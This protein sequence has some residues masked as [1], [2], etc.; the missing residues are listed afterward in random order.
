MKPLIEIRGL[1]FTYKPEKGEP[2]D[3]L[4]GV[5]LEISEGEYVV[6][7]GHNGSGKSTLARHLNALLIPT[8]GEVRVNGI[9][10]RD[11]SRL[12]DLRSTVGMVF[13]HPD[14]Q[15]VATIVEEDIAF[16]PENLG[17]P[18]LELLKRVDWALERVNL[19]AQRLRPPHALSG[20]QK[21]RVCIAGVLAMKPRIL[22]LDEATAM[23]DP[24]GRREVLDVARRMN[25]QEGVTVIA[26]THLMEEAADADR[27]VVMSE[28]RVVLS[29]PPREV[30]AQAD[31]LRELK[32]DV[33]QVTRLAHAVRSKRPDFPADVLT[34][35]EFVA[36]ARAAGLAGVSAPPEAAPLAG[37]PVIEMRH[38]A[39][40]Y[41][42]DTPLQVRAIHDITLDVPRGHVIGIIG[43]TGSGKSTAIQH[44]NALLRP[45][46]GEARVLGKD[47]RK[48]NLDTRDIRRRVG[49]VFQQ[50]ETQL[51]EHYV[52]DDIAY[53]PRN[54]KLSREE[55]R[56][57]VRAAME[58]VGLGFEAFKDRIT[59]GLSGGEMRRVA[60][61]GVLALD[62]EVLVL[63]E[64]TSGLDPAG[65]DQL[66]QTIL[67]LRDHGVTL[68]LVSHNMEELARACDRI[69]VI[70]DGRTMLAGTPAEVFSQE[71]QLRELALAPPPVTTAMARLG[72]A[73]VLTVEEAMQR[74]EAAQ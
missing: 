58:R 6:V 39:H 50:P 72:H 73:G 43:H 62:P 48:P 22:V 16:G 44:F 47:T 1:R 63:D 19:G 51:F 10:T 31:R 64:P 49:L 29:G 32:V 55:V 33:P 30:F 21:Q 67:A 26:I 45:H 42:R 28:G 70:G 56:A 9:D 54:L 46:E 61:A 4:K 25:K 12:R 53:G 34:I 65:R 69:Y 57:R 11:A 27:V 8:E 74:L 20:G 59:F 18:R 38:V 36:R 60:I 7:F 35:E 15:I 3:A 24:I 13:Q 37:E 23:L 5:D 40:D 17:V 41:M 2:V 14:N 68:V 52:G 66:Y 71:D